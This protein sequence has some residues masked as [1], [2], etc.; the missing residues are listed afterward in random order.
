VIDQY[1]LLTIIGVVIL[2][3]GIALLA[4]KK[5]GG[6][7]ALLIGLLWLFTMGIYYTFTY[8]GVYKTGLYPVANIIGIAI[9][10]IGLAVVIYYW[11]RSGVL[12]R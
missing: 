7:L 11:S 5:K 12:R 10:I 8:T 4:T 6:F 1:T 3:V 2:I 9:L